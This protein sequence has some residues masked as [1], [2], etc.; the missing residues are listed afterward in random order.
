MNRNKIIETNWIEIDNEENGRK[1]EAKNTT[2]KNIKRRYDFPL[3]NL[4]P[5]FISIKSFL[6]IIVGLSFNITCLES[7]KNC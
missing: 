4:L 2:I 5:W 7:N 6:A 1:K 3:G